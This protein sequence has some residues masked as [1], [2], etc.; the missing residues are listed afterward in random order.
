MMPPPA[1]PL[2][3]SS[4]LDRRIQ[5]LEKFQRATMNILEDLE[6]ERR[7]SQL[8]Q[9]AA[10]NLLEDMYEEQRKLTDT[11]RALMNI[12]EDIEL[13]RNEA[14]HAKSLLETV[15]KELEAFSYSVSHDLRA[16][17][18]AI[19]GFAEAIMEDYAPRLDDEGKRYITLIRQNAHQMGQLIDDLLNFSRLG[20]QQMTESRI[21][22]TVLAKAVFDELAGVIPERKLVIRIGSVPPARGDIVLV[23]QVLVNLLSNAIKFTGSKTR[24]F[25][26]FGYLPDSDGGAYYVK[27]NGVGFDMQ[28]A[29]KLFGVFQRL[30]AVTEFEGTGVGLALVHRIITRHGGRVW[31][32]GAVDKG[33]IFYFTLPKE[34]K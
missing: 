2:A 8:I 5:R 20:R 6:E 7:S 33:A 13:E 30:H 11:Q 28:Y 24:A 14:E 31:A 26:E 29:D 25:I 34:V 4:E 10:V 1:F 22:M 21:D 27:D 19:S 18:R 9:K 15:N 32:E 16:P 23:R 17:L 12:L 3:G